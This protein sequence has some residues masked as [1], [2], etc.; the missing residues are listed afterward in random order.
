MARLTRS[1]AAVHV[2]AF[3]TGSAAVASSSS[4]SGPPPVVI[5]G[6]RDCLKGL[7][8][9]FTGELPSLGRPNAIALAR[10]YGACVPLLGTRL[11]L[12]MRAAA[13]APRF[14]TIARSPR[15][16]RQ[17]PLTLSL[18]QPHRI[19]LRGGAE[20]SRRSMRPASCTSSG[21]EARQT[22]AACRPPAPLRRALGLR[23]RCRFGRGT[24]NRRAEP[25]LTKRR[26]RRHSHRPFRG[27]QRLQRVPRHLLVRPC[28]LLA[29]R[30]SHRCRLP[31]DQNGNGDS[32]VSSTSKTS[33]RSICAE[34]LRSGRSS[35]SRRRPTL[36][37]RRRGC[38]CRRPYSRR[39]LS[40]EVRQHQW[41]PLPS[42]ARSGARP[43]RT[44]VKPVQVLGGPRQDRGRASWRLQALS[45][46]CARPPSSLSCRTRVACQLSGGPARCGA[47]VDRCAQGR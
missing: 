19:D 29:S 10:K 39:R 37:S 20:V 5:A 16:H 25:P 17:R 42:P 32:R 26:T 46:R 21:R 38:L 9:V 22:S 34:I 2:V 12:L 44:T 3:P 36:S 23:T 45:G 13:D 27:S 1:A 14:L 40:V 18:V 7:K 4:S 41:S 30:C 6:R 31:Q 24:H 43:R 15:P 33:T 28:S 47:P 8:L 11:C 35:C